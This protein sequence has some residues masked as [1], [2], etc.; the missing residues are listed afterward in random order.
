[1]RVL[2]KTAV[3]AIIVCS[4]ASGQ[5][6]GKD[7]LANH[8]RGELEFLASDV[9]QGRGSG[10]HDE[11]VTALYLSSELR[12]L[13]IEPG[14]DNGSYVQDA[15][16][17]YKF[18]EGSK[19]WD[20]R[21][22]IGVLPGRSA[23][24]KNEVIM[25]SAHMDHLGIGKPVN[26]DGIYNGADDDASGCVAVLELA[27]FLAHEEPPKRTIIFVF[28]G[29]EETG[30]QGNEYFL[31]HPPVPLDKIVANLEFEMIGRADPAVKPDELWL[32]GF[33]RSNL[34]PELARHG[35]KLVADPH[36]AQRFFQ[37]SDNYALARR[38][39]IAHTVSSFGLH[40]DYHRPSDDL[41]HIDFQHLQQ[42]TESIMLPVQWLANSDFK[43]SWLEGKKP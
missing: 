34:G 5:K 39:V 10:T 11:L 30:G 13:G 3:F 35:A 22:V 33:E 2:A 36:P 19:H 1:L 21:N 29:S 23:T 24:M 43:P 16:G 14:G 42:A 28:F 12:Q 18:P 26:S 8:I 4:L 38:G 15:S 32:T 9:L 41:G 25:L 40:K 27:R 31:A 17:E 7:L 20:T 37:R 6:A